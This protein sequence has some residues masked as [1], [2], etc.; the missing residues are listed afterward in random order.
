MQFPRINRAVREARA[1][2]RKLGA[3]GVTKTARSRVTLKKGSGLPIERC[4]G[5]GRKYIGEVCPFCGG[6]K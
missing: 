1:V 6:G 4:L 5:C 3:A 2:K